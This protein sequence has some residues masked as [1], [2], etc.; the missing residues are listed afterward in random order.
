MA[1]DLCKNGF[2]WKLSIYLTKSFNHFYHISQ[3][4]NGKMTFPLGTWCKKMQKW[5]SWYFRRL[6]IHF[7]GKLQ[8]GPFKKYS[9][10]CSKKSI[11]GFCFKAQLIIQGLKLLTKDAWH[12]LCVKG[13]LNH[14]IENS[15]SPPLHRH[16][17]LHLASIYKKV[18]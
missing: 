2:K 11:L 16:F 17:Y 4:F 1:L 10:S 6:L 5:A 15:P 8:Q 18:T 12:F 9:C 7:F 13:C 3:P 14:E